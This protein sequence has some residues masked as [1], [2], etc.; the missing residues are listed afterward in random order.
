MNTRRK[1]VTHCSN[2]SDYLL[3]TLTA[4][5]QQLHLDGTT[6]VSDLVLFDMEL[7]FVA[8]KQTDHVTRHRV[9]TQRSK[10]LRYWTAI[11]SRV[12]RRT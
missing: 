12:K 4:W 5:L 6:L 1:T 7:H 9:D 10:G 8:G 2:A 11:S 3:S